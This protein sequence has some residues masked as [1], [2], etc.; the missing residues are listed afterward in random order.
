MEIMQHSLKKNESPV[1]Y[2]DKAW[3]HDKHTHAD[4]NA[5]ILP[6]QNN[7]HPVY[8]QP[9]FD[10]RLWIAGSETAKAHPGYMDG[11][12]SSANIVFDQ[13]KNS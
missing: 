5:Y 4:Y 11:A 2:I 8:H 7:G 3:R 1:E 12:V 10:G 9:Y 13:V 6:H